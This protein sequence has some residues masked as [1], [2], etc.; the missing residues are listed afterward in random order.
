MTEELFEAEIHC[1][2]NERFG[3]NAFDG[4]IGKD[5]SVRM[6]MIQRTGKLLG[7]TVSDD[8]RSVR[9]RIEGAGIELAP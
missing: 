8:G 2:E 7:A 6:G 9:F 5:I 4:S 1:G 3:R